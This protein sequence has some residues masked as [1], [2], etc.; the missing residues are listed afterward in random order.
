MTHWQTI[1]RRKLTCLTL[2]V[3]RATRSLEEEKRGARMGVFMRFLDS[4]T[5]PMTHRDEDRRVKRAWNLIAAIVLFG[6]IWR[7][8]GY[9]FQSKVE[10]SW[11][12]NFQH[13]S[14]FHQEQIACITC[15]SYS[16]VCNGIIIWDYAEEYWWR[17][18]VGSRKWRL[19]RQLRFLNI[20]LF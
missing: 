14:P 13:H 12:S 18:D 20:L 2:I 16:L 10:F 8:R 15:L 1:A 4:I 17:H 6:G 9:M 3:S 5:N 7:T 19:D 11:K